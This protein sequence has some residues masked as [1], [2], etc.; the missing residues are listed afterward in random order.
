MHVLGEAV[1]R[2]RVGKVTVETMQGQLEH[3]AETATL[4]GHEFGIVPFAVASPVAPA[5][6]FVLYDNDLAVVETLSGRLHI[7]EPDII[8]RYARWLELL[9]QAA[10]T[11]AE[12]AEMC[13]RAAADYRGLRN[14]RG[15]LRTLPRL[16]RR[17]SHE[18][19]TEHGPPACHEV[20][21]VRV[22]QG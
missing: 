11:G 21:L 3:L 14:P 19:I 8:A 12:A 22:V 7:S 2:T 6:G 16:R 10:V 20:I 5:S 15:S 1:L 9:R 4:P 18:V 17:P 13:R